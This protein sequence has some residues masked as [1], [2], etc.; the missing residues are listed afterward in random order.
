MKFFPLTK[1]LIKNFTNNSGSVDSRSLK[2]PSFA[3]NAK[4]IYLNPILQRN[5]IIKDSKGKKRVVSIE[6]TGNIKDKPAYEFL[7]IIYGGN[8]YTKNNTV[9]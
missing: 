1:I 2:L 3:T 7:K 4:K 9:R 8:I 6:I 5:A